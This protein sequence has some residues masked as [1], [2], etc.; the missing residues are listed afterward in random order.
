MMENILPLGDNIN[1]IGTLLA[2]IDDDDKDIA[3]FVGSGVSDLLGI[4]TWDDILKKMKREYDSNEDVS[5]KVI[6]EEGH[7]T[8]AQ[9]IYNEKNDDFYRKFMKRQFLPEKAFH[10]SLHIKILST[11]NTILTTNYDASF[12]DA[13]KDLNYYM[14]KCCCSPKKWEIQK[15]PSLKM[16]KMNSK[17]QLVYLHGNNKAEKYVFLEREY[18]LFYPSYY[19]KQDSSRLEDFL[20]GI[21]REFTL[22]FIGFSFN[23]KVFRDFLIGSL[24]QIRNE[25]K[26]MELVKGFE[27]SPE[28]PKHFAIFRNNYESDENK[29]RIVETLK[30]LVNII[31]IEQHFQVE[32]L[33]QYLM[34]ESALF[35][36]KGDG[37]VDH[38]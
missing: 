33:L 18:E 15:L 6:K 19:G 29:K 23:D 2:I 10:Y 7:A 13:L 24:K 11:F 3:V 28:I 32:T 26:R 8:I 31:E 25:R 14:K 27:D 9:K 21:F 37:E 1:V 17:P 16:S 20:K 36:V 34:E 4:K 30:D 5:E 12:E 35:V 22:V 38:A